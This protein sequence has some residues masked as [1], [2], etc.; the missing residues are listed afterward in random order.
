M[1]KAKQIYEILFPHGILSTYIPASIILW[2]NLWSALYNS[3]VVSSGWLVFA[4][5]FG[6]AFSLKL[7]FSTYCKK[8]SILMFDAMMA[9]VFEVVRPELEAKFNAFMGSGCRTPETML[10]LK[11]ESEEIINREL[12]RRKSRFLKSNS[13]K[14]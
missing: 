14:S 6:I 3:F 9:E 13:D 1:S 11:I 5:C 7:F 8:K 2:M 4:N 10:L 12:Q